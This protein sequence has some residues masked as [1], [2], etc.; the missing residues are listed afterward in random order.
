MMEGRG[1]NEQEKEKRKE[2]DRAG[3]IAGG[4]AAFSGGKCVCGFAGVF[5]S[6]ADCIGRGVSG[7]E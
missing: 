7:C 6:Y 3:S 4:F 5:R 1:W 2:N